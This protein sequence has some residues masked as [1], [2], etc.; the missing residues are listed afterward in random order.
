MQ[1]RENCFF[2]AMP[3]VFSWMLAGVF[4][5]ILV[6]L[7]LC[8]PW[9]SQYYTNQS[10]LANEKL[11]PAVIVVIFMLFALCRVWENNH[12]TDAK[13][14]LWM[15]RA[16]FLLVLAVQFVIARSCWYKMGWDIYNVYTMAE[17]LGLGKPL[18]EPEYFQLCPNNAPLTMLQAVPMWFAGKLG[19][20]VPFV[21]L[22]Y[23]DAVLLNA[24]AYVTVRI[25]QTLSQSRVSRAFALVVSIGWIAL[26]PYILYPYTDTF[27]ILFPVLAVYAYLRIERPF[28]KWLVISLLCFFGATIKPTVLIVLIAMVILGI[29]RFLARKD[30]SAAS[31][32]R[33]LIVAAAIIIGMLPGKIFQDQ[34]TE[35][36]AGSAVP[37]GQLSATHYL[38]LGM[39]GDTFGGHSPDDVTFSTSFETLEE[40]Q[41]ANIRCAWERLTQRSL[42]ENAKFFAVKAYKAYA[43]G[44]FASHQSFLEFETPK[45]TDALSKLLRDFYHDDG[46]FMPYCQTL[47]QGL[48]LGVLILC[49]T[50]AVRMRRHPVVALLALTLLGVTAYLLLFEVWPRYLFLYAPVF[51]AL[52]AMAFD[53]PLSVKR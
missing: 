19:L 48:W 26:S 6:L 42:V 31:F 20:A 14:S 4:G 9:L 32:K 1:R 36:L 3:S 37:Q 12:A 5:V 41:A 22:P 18:T 52:S 27:S 35:Y 29:C 17:E 33:V 44:S 47:V 25:V 21:V 34:S 40:R 46:R 2:S 39:N 15:L 49:V 53:R 23:I 11:L 45:R 7:A 38:M 16:M 43:D 50:A 10:L 28:V 8:Q 24:S 51:V 30:L 13:R